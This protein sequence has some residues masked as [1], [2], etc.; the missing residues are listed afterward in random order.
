GRKVGGGYEDP[1]PRTTPRGG[2]SDA[3]RTVGALTP[4]FALAGRYGVARLRFKPSGSG[5]FQR[6]LALLPVARAQ[7]VGL[8][9]VEH[10]QYFLRIAA[11]AAISDVRE[12]DHALRID[13]EGRALG[14][15]LLVHDAERLG[16]I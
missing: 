3:V 13:Q 12:A 10:A 4:R 9:R 16:Q 11:D 6:F 5:G 2:R 14:D 15:A 1:P 8:Q 7:F